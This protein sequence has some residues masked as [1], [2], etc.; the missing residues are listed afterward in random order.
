MNRLA[1]TRDIFVDSQISYLL[2]YDFISRDSKLRAKWHAMK[3][4]KRK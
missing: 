1:S 4:E 3:K 2:S